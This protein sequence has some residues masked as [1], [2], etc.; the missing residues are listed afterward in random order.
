[1][2]I[3]NKRLECLFMIYYFFLSIF[4]IILYIFFIYGFNGKNEEI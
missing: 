4:D 2:K 3:L 1:M